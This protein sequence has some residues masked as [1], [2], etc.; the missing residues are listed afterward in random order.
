MAYICMYVYM[1]GMGALCAQSSDLNS[2]KNFWPDEKR[3]CRNQ[4]L[5]TAKISGMQL[6]D[7]W[8]ESIS[9][10]QAKADRRFYY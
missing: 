9:K 7:L 1:K 4:S 5:L 8:K 2:I 3:M 10:S 6:R